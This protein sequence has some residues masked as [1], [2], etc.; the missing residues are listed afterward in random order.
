MIRYVVMG[1]YSSDA[2]AG[3]IYNP[4]DRK[5]STEKFLRN[6]GGKWDEGSSFVHVNHPDYDFIGIII[7]KDEATAKATADVIRATGNYESFNFFRAW[8]PQEYSNISKKASEYVG[9]FSST[10]DRIKEDK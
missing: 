6:A 2:I 5:K 1:K 9:T 7:V 8:L 4:Q 10:T 3:L